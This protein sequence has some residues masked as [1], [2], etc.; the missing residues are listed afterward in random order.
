MIKNEIID[1]ILDCF[2]GA[3]GGMSFVKL[4]FFLEQMEQMEQ[5]SEKGDIAAKEILLIAKRFVK[6]IE[7]ANNLTKKE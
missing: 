2:S 3:D 7:L 4:K 5:K 6:I 1:P